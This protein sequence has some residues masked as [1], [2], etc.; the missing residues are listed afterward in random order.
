[1]EA[2]F[3]LEAPLGTGDLRGKYRAA[4]ED[5]QGNVLKSHGRDH[6][7]LVFVKLD[8]T[9]IKAARS[10]LAGPLKGRLTSAAE[11]LD[12]IVEAR[13][14][15]RRGGAFWAVLISAPGYRVLGRNL[16]GFEKAFQ[17]GMAE[18]E[19]GD[20]IREKWED[21]YR[22]QCH[23]MILIADESRANVYFL[24]RAL[25]AEVSEF[26][27]VIHI[28]FGGQ[29]RNGD[30]D[31]IE[32]FGYV[33]GRSQP[34]MIEEDLRSESDGIFVW[35][36]SAG[37][38][39]VLVRDPFGDEGA[40]GSY[41]VFRKLEQDVSGFKDHELALANALGLTDEEEREIAGALVV[42]RFEDGTPIALSNHPTISV[43]VGRRGGVV[44]NNFDYRAD[45][46]GFKCPLHAHIRKM[47]SRGSGVLDAEEQKSRR[48]ARR[49]IT[50]GKREVGPSGE[51]VD[52][53]KGGVGLLFMSYQSSIEGQ[54]EFI[55]KN[56]ANASD[57][58]EGGSGIDPLIGQTNGENLSRWPKRWGRAECG[59]VSFQFERFVTL[60]G[61]E[62]FFAPSISSLGKL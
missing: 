33:D 41:F 10:W 1:M 3:D 7:A 13:L 29:L 6:V 50:Y 14:T 58:P 22:V 30:G 61:G 43:S 44:P 42:G 36:P 62:Y 12:Q 16:E 31:G 54:F 11:Q 8:S 49:G 40:S 39:L 57:K 55:Q 17:E 32:H 9:Q 4:L 52:R 60:K 25:E 45:A 5:L 48:M 38:S 37:P 15:G 2:L 24:A 34:I 35:N 47:N 59:S 26:A 46:Q 53:P 20:P 19:L 56:W 23:A 27:K 18:R 51:L 21:A 28:E